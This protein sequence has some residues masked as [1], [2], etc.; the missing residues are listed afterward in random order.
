MRSILATTVLAAALWGGAAL[1]QSA[2]PS[3]DAFSPPG[4]MTS[5]GT[6][7]T[8]TADVGTPDTEIGDEGALTPV[9][10]VVIDLYSPGERSAPAPERPAKAEPP[11]PRARQH[12]NVP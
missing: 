6:Q 1:A 11:A 12:A 10:P 7:V 9:S 5:I 3:S 8:P 4:D 2:P